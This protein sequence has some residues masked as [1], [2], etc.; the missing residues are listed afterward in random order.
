MPCKVFICTSM[1]GFISRE[2]GDIDWL[3]EDFLKETQVDAGKQVSLEA[4]RTAFA[5]IHGTMSETAILDR[6]DRF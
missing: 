4:V 6:E 2:N 5:K 3:D 1:D